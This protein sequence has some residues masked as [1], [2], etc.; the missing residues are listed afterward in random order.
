MY[1]TTPATGEGRPFLSR[2]SGGFDDA[3]ERSSDVDLDLISS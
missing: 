1:S 2:G 3:G